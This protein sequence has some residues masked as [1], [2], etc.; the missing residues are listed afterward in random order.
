MM[1]RRVALVLLAGAVAG[2]AE[3][4]DNGPVVRVAR[5]AGRPCV[6]VDGR[7]TPARMFW[8]RSNGRRMP[9]TETWRRHEWKL[10]PHTSVQ[11]GA[12]C[13][14]TEENPEGRLEV[15]GLCVRSP[16]G[17][18]REL[19]TEPPGGAYP[20]LQTNPI[21]FAEGKTYVVSFEIRGSGLGWFRLD[22]QQQEPGAY[23]Y[24]ALSVPWDDPD[25][26]TLCSDARQARA[27]G[28]RFITYFAPL[29]WFPEGEENWGPFDA[30]ARQLLA[31]VPDALL[32]P[33]VSVNAPEWWCR[34]HPDHV[35]ATEAGPEKSWASVASP[36]Y[37]KEAGE[38]LRKVVRHFQ[39]TFP[40]NF[41]GIHFSGQNTAEWFYY[42]SQYRLVGY[43]RQTRDAFRRYLAACG[44][45]D[46]ATAEVPTAESLRAGASLSERFYDPVRERRIV[47]FMRYLQVE[48]ADAVGGLATI[49]REE[50]GGRKLVMAFYGYSW[51]H[52]GYGIGS[53]NTGHYGLM[54]LLEKW[55]TSLDAISGPQS[56]S[57][58][59]EID[60]VS[61]VMSPAE[62]IARHGILWV[63]EDDLRVHAVSERKAQ[64]VYGLTAD[65]RGD[66]RVMTRTVGMEVARGL[67]GWWMDLFGSGWYSDP[68]TWEIARGLHRFEREMMSRPLRPVDLA[69]ICDEESVVNLRLAKGWNASSGNCLRQTRD[70][71][72]TCGFSFGQYLLEDVLS[73]PPDVKAELHF[74]T[75]RPQDPARLR[76]HMRAR[77]NV[78]FAWFWA[79]P[80]DVTGFRLEPVS[81]A[82]VKAR[83]TPRGRSLGLCEDLVGGAGLVA[84]L[85]RVA[86]AA[87][88]ETLACWPDG[89]AAVAL[90]RNPRGTGFSVFCGVPR[91][92]AEFLALIGRLSGAHA[93]LSPE[94]V[95]K[96]VVWPGNG[97]V[98][99]Q[100]RT[101]AGFAVETEFRGDVVDALSGKDLGRGPSV[102]LRLNVGDVVILKERDAHAAAPVRTR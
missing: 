77:P 88:D 16:E 101:D 75:W 69:A 67:G 23:R 99:V 30:Q 18:V 27:S 94:T 82:E 5:C 87:A 29:C 12:F 47:Q 21:P 83:I 97:F 63:N 28:C 80:P 61:S 66:R 86:D 35:M 96:A 2:N 4:V 91:V 100:A 44:D 55:G 70:L 65:L 57:G 49:C 93:F 78:T 8:G 25:Q 40:E 74:A 79:P 15:R 6:V 39:E 58:R 32:I 45:P 53:A 14:A 81:P 84:P 71:L 46:A 37:R 72:P 41:A 59:N 11:K 52:A 31:A 64:A 43:D 34:R 10:T 9:L 85:Y 76:E 54:R 36:L 89:S 24:H 68:G 20:G 1:V 33:R 26:T 60:G 17:E 73:S 42:K 62:T 48:M 56:Y 92:S 50:T 95:G 51:E 3:A 7:P 13:F 38:Y 90:R 102:R 22:L 19:A 98:T